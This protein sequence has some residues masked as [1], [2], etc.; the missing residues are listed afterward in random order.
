MWHTRSYI[1]V[2][3]CV[4][5]CVCA[6]VPF[7]DTK[8]RY[9]AYNQAQL[10][11][12][13]NTKGLRDTMRDP[14]NVGAH[15]HLLLADTVSEYFISL[16]SFSTSFSQDRLIRDMC[17][18]SRK[19]ATCGG[20]TVKNNVIRCQRILMTVYYNCDQNFGHCPSH[21]LDLPPSADEMGK[22]K[23]NSYYM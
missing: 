3:V 21:R 13:A 1:C 2:C 14:A 19:L 5:V 4:C 15:M 22:G 8:F 17:D 23:T 16:Y 7:T 11:R 18:N 10:V 20:K 9:G 12:V 6:R